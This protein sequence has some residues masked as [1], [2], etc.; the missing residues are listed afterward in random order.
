M[1][2]SSHLGLRTVVDLRSSAE[3]H[4]GASALAGTR[5]TVLIPARSRG[6]H[7]P[8]RRR[9]RADPRPALRADAGRLRGQPVVAASR[10]LARP[11]CAA[12]LV[13]CAAG[14]TGPGSSWRWSLSATGVPDEVVAADYALTAASCPESFLRRSC[15]YQTPRRGGTPRCT[16][17][18]GTAPSA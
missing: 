5:I 14:R 6:R 10:R 11:G 8:R 16:R 12:H 7:R 3:A 18:T 4:G 2:R 17:S 9:R 15:P 1:P 13:H